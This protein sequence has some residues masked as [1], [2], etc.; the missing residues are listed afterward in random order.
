MKQPIDLAMLLSQKAGE[1]LVDAYHFSQNKDATSSLKEAEA[2][3]Q[4]IILFQTSMEAI[5]NEEVLNHP[6]LK[7]VKTEQEELHRHFKSLSFKNKWIRAYET[8][9]LHETEYL[10]DYLTFY[11][12]FRTPIT[13]PKSRYISVQKYRFKAVC[14]GLENGWYTFQLLFAILGKQLTSWDEFCEQIGL[15]T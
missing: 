15:Q 11:T 6:L 7:E 12:E 9:Q 8:L 14:D 5:I 1:H 4:A 3:I 13:H 2:C 10:N